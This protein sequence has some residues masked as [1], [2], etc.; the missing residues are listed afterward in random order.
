MY[1]CLISTHDLLLPAAIISPQMKH[2]LG[3][4][5]GVN[6]KFIPILFLL[7]YFFLILETLLKKNIQVSEVYAGGGGAHSGPIQPTD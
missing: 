6:I 2:H 5:K 4:K 3:S 7:T 1:L